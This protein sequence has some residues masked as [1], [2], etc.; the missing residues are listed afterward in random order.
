MDNVDLDFDERKQFK[1]SAYV[2]FRRPEYASRASIKSDGMEILGKK[3]S[4]SILQ[5]RGRNWHLE[6]EEQAENIALDPQ[7][8]S[9]I[10]RHL[11]DSKKD[12]ELT[13]MINQVSNPGQ[14]QLVGTEE[15]SECSLS[16]LM[17]RQLF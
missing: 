15:R 3:I 11:A 13:R 8:R 4:V 12:E 16:V 6:D 7:R 5:R 10:M 9:Q 14:V 17:G 1:G 2:K